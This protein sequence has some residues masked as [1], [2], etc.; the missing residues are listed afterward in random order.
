MAPLRRPLILAALAS[1][2][3]ALWLAATT[4]DDPAPIALHA[5][6]VYAVAA[7]IAAMAAHEGESGLRAPGLRQFLAAFLRA[8]ALLLAV[9]GLARAVGMPALPHPV[10]TTLALLATC[11][12][13]AGLSALWPLVPGA[14]KPHAWLRIALPLLIVLGVQ[15]GNA[16]RG[17][18]SPLLPLS[19][20]H[21]AQT[22][23][24]TAVTG[25]GTR[26]AGSALLAMAGVGVLALLAACLPGRR[27]PLVLLVAGWLGFGALVW[28]R[29]PPPLPRADMSANYTVAALAELSSRDNSIA[30]IART[31]PDAALASALA[32]A[33]DR[34]RRQIAIWPP[35]AV[36]DPVQRARNLLLIAAVPD[37][38]D[39]EPLQSHLPLLVRAE[40]AA[41]IPPGQLP[42][43]LATIASH[44]EQGSVVARE[45]LPRLGLPANTGD[46]AAVRKRVAL[47]AAKLGEQA[48]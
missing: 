11:L 6:A 44:P 30:P 37:L 27:W 28:Q 40:L 15:W 18:V 26:A 25:T 2:G 9:H 34:V 48:P 12:F 33:L 24:Q 36:A 38:Y 20:G 21:W 5:G 3:V 41:R 13:C 42:A 14:G 29:P 39:T 16:G 8:G 7:L 46:E 35:A 22:A 43:V 32:S 17:I 1:G 45:T 4:L 23:I 10:S 31:A 19:P 47:Y